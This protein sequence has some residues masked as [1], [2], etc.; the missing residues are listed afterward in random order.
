MDMHM[1]AGLKQAIQAIGNANKLAKAL[2]VTRQAI[3][4]WER[5]PL[6]RV[7]QI[8]KLTGIPKEELRPDFFGEPKRARKKR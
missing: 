2:G 1:D 4:F 3:Y 7:H 5:I 8:E 6:E